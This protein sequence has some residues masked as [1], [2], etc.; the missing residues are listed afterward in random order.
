MSRE[1][2]ITESISYDVQECRFCGAEVGLGEDIPEDELVKSGIAVL[3]GDGTVSISEERKGNW[4]VEVEFAGE[5]SDASP[6]TVTGHILCTECAEDLHDYSQAD[7]LYRGALPNELTSG[8]GSPDLPVSNR[9]LIAI[10][11]FVLL[12]IIFL[13]I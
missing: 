4:D 9:A 3:V 8:A 5:Q 11:G 1:T 10:V 13:M 7:E 2:A 6:P 12:I